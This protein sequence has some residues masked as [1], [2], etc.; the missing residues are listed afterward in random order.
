MAKGCW[1]NV[2]VGITQEAK[3]V[4][5]QKVYLACGVRLVT[6]WNIVKLWNI[7]CYGMAVNQRGHQGHV[8]P[9]DRLTLRTHACTRET[10]S[11]G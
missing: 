4:A 5:P 2:M 9:Q 8:P 10:C 7:V 6:K 3:G 1:R 11:E